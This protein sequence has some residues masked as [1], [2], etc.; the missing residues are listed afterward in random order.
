MYQFFP[1]NYPLSAKVIRAI[2]GIC[3]RQAE[4]DEIMKV[5]EKVDPNNLET[6]T[7]AWDNM[8][9]RLYAMA[10]QAES[11]R[12]F[13]TACDEYSR[14]VGYYHNAQFYLDSYDP[15][16]LEIY[17][18]YRECFKRGTQYADDGV[19]VEVHVPYEDTFLY[20]YYL[21]TPKPDPSGKSPTVVWF[22]G[23]DS[24]AEEAYF[25]VCKDFAR[26]GFNC[27]I[28]DGPGQGASLRLNKIPTR[29][30]YEAAGSAAFD[31]LETL[32]DV[33]LSRVAV[34]A[35]SLGGYY[36]PRI[37]SFEH[38]YAAL[39]TYGARYDAG[40]SW[41]ERY[42]A[43]GQKMALSSYAMLV[44]GVKTMEEA[45]EKFQAFNLEGVLKGVTCDALI[46]FGND[47][48]QQKLEEAQR[49]CREMVNAKSVTFKL[50][51]KEEGACGHV[52]Q[53]NLT[54][55]NSFSGDW[56]MDRFGMT[57]KA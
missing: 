22:G 27:L 41:R 56:L 39:I 31:Y 48:P 20:G 45:V 42:A 51:T 54:L 46:V 21:K 5:V 28:M 30:D 2:G 23:L 49:I 43:G 18:K 47:D 16:R 53:D 11:N 24:T 3:T 14:A 26:R 33:D 35:W 25:A 34:M 15:R 17:K 55:G 10:A 1:G 57:P 52:C 12:H 29:Y 6:W 13:V 19:P 36:A 40:K 7:N 38:R 8:G 44:H 9:D 37:A 50:F 4:F 32:D